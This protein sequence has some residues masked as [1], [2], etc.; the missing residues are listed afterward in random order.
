MRM[1]FPACDQ[2]YW[3]FQTRLEKNVSLDSTDKEGIKVLIE[4][5]E[6]LIERLYN[7]DNNSLN[8]VIETLCES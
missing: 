4:T 1:L 6:K 3:R 2:Q 8:K 7:D 5:A